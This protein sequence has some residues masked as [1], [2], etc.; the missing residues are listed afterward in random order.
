[1]KYLLIF[2]LTISYFAISQNLDSNENQFCDFY[3]DSLLHMNV[4]TD[5]LTID[6]NNQNLNKFLSYFMSNYKYSKNAQII[7]NLNI[8][9]I[10]DTNGL[11]VRSYL[12]DKD[13]NEY[14]Q[15]EIEALNTI[16]VYDQS[17][18]RG[19]CRGVYVP[20]KFLLPLKIH[21]RD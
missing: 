7:M 20:V 1:M 15:N 16:N 19:K 4:Y 14:S 18:I 2:F 11:I 17:I 13:M 6:D 3:F 9:L 12:L 8:T 5:Y 10:L 21:A